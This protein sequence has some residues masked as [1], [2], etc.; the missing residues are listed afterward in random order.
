MNPS[1]SHSTFSRNGRSSSERPPVVLT[2]GGSDPTGGAG[3]QADIK[4]FQHFGVHGLSVITAVTVQNTRGVISTNPVSAEL[5]EA[6][7]NALSEE[8]AIGAIKIGML[9]TADVVLVVS[10]FVK[11]QQVPAVLDPILASSNGVRFLEEGALEALRYTL[12]PLASILTPNLPEISALTR[13]P[14]H[15]EAEMLQAALRLMESGVKSVLL[16][17]GH[18]AGPDAR[19][20]FFDG[21]ETE[22]I[23]APRSTKQ[24][25]GTGCVLSSAIASGLA[26]GMPMRESVTAAKDFITEMIEEA[27]PL[28]HG[29]DIFQFTS[30]LVV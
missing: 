24:V 17:G 15:S 8:I 19:D 12:S 7:L 21:T 4:T 27:V 6:Q 3:I 11:K 2:I 14:V 18:A 9:T 26:L 30:S 23:S 10:D 13:I 20:L 16:K 29:Q 28:G 22:W 25:H 1:N 5:V